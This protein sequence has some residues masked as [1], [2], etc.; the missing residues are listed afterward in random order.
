MPDYTT[1]PL[2]PR[3]RGPTSLALVEA[4]D[5]VWGG[6]WCMGF[7]SEGVGKG[8]TP[9]GTVP[10]RRHGCGPAR[11]TPRSSTTATTAWA[12]ASSGARRAAADQEPQARTYDRVSTRCRTGGSRA[13]SSTSG[14]RRRGVAAAG[15]RRRARR[16][17]PA[18]RRDGRELPRGCRGPAGPA[19]F[20][21][22]GTLAMFERRTDSSGPAAS[23]SP[24]GWC[25]G[26]TADR[27]RTRRPTPGEDARP[28]PAD[29]RAPPA[30][31]GRVRTGRRSFGAV[32]PNRKS[33]AS[34]SMPNAWLS[35]PA[36]SAVSTSFFM[37]P[38]SRRSENRILNRSTRPRPATSPLTW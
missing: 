38:R 4:H 15:A 23:A 6:G 28:G 24:A 5:G 36:A 32:Y 21:H 3:G 27:R 13:S 30:R 10:R 2:D 1:R 8:K 35:A 16:D 9:A 11:R 33:S 14:H 12:G 31:C 29:A 34:A 37:N 17:R 22:N 19:S 20:L 25:A 26:S 7:H 18:R